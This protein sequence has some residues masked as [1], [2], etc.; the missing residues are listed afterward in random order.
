MHPLRALARALYL[1]LLSIVRHAGLHRVFHS[2]LARRLVWDTAASG[3]LM[4][5]D[6]DPEKFVVLA[7]DRYIGRTVYLSRQPFDFPKLERV[8][9]LLQGRPLKLLIDVG[10]NVGTICIPAVKRGLFERAIAIEPEPRNFSLLTANVSIN[11]LAADIATHNLALGARDDDTILF[12]LSRTN[13]GD[14]HAN[15][16]DSADGCE[17]I[18]VRSET[19]DRVVGNLI[20]GSALVWMDTQGFEGHVLAGA[21]KALRD[22]PPLVIEFWP[23]ALQRSGG[24]PRLKA[25]LAPYSFFYDLGEAADIKRGFSISALEELASRLGDGDAQTDLL[26]L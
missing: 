25:A 13:F 16:G 26:V 3:S 8:M 23:S 11:Q 15:Y 18:R 24:L 12:Q 4:L 7:G 17:T 21:T 1:F 5:S 10:A 14:H 19:F 20:P 22:T 6:G 2:Q 9:R